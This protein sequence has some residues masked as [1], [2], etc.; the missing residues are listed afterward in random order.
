MNKYL[1][2]YGF[3]SPK[4]TE[5]PKKDLGII[6]VIP[7]HNEENVS[8]TLDSLNSC[9]ASQCGVKTIIVINQSEII[10]EEISTQNHKSESEIIT[11]KANNPVF[12]VDVIFEKALPKKHAGVGLSRKIGMDEAVNLFHQI[13]KKGII[14]ALDADCEVEPNYLQ[15]IENHFEKNPKSN[16]CSIR[17]AHPLQGKEYSDDV[18]KGIIN[19]ELHLRYYNQAM[20]FC[21]FPFAYHTVGSSMA[22]KTSAYEKQGGMN[23]RKA[24][25]DFYFLQKIIELGNFTELNSSCVIPSPRISDRVPFGT[26]K[27]IGDW[28][29]SKESV[30]FTY[31][32]NSF[33]QLKELIDNILNIYKKD[34]Y[35][36]KSKVLL[37]FMDSINFENKVEEIRK[38][39]TNY[40]NFEKRFFTFFNAFTVLKY[41]HFARDN[42]F[43]NLPVK[44]EARKLLNQVYQQDCNGNSTIQILEIYRT[45]EKDREV[46]N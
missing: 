9:T 32:L 3:Q 40:L 24:G 5:P 29:E 1:A 27:A 2:K 42:S 26:G 39:T 19:Y 31:D 14:V 22:V 17:Y 13:E 44:E 18:Y 11:W 7:C 41:V 15:E 4:I 20:R 8:R 12:D 34:S 36:I 38:N 25:E 23:K 28:I 30:Y 46:G 45:I 21:G 10:S 43:P 35:T 6:V 16:G 37:Q 33:I